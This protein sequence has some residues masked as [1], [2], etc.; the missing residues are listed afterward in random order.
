MKKI[1]FTLCLAAALTGARGQ[2]YIDSYRFGAA[3]AACSGLLLDS[4][5]APSA[6]FA[7]S[8]RKLRTDYTGNCI[9]VRNATTTRTFTIGFSGNYLD[10]VRLKDSCASADCFVR[11][12]YDQSGEALNATQTTNSYQP[13]ITTSGTIFSKNGTPSIDFDGTDDHFTIGNTSSF[14]FLHNGTTSFV[15]SVAA[16]DQSRSQSIFSNSNGGGSQRRGYLMYFT[17]SNR[18]A[19]YTHNETTANISNISANNSVATATILLM[20]EIDADNATAAD[21]SALYINGG[22]AIKNNTSTGAVTTSSS[23]SEMFIG[24]YTTSLTIQGAL[25]GSVKEIVVYNTD[26]S[27]KR[28][29]MRGNINSFYSIY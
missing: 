2:I 22:S 6:K 12:W 17:T 19:N 11:T 13:K 5:C 15:Y 24:I 28:V 10:T 9:E 4:D 25:D 21:R 27:S 8:L 7:V 1:L 23:F 16:Q 26:Q 18:I 29:D 14:N 3:A 20:D